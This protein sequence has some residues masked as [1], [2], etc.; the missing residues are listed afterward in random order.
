MTKKLKDIKISLSH[1]MQ[2][3]VVI[4]PLCIVAVGGWHKIEH[5]IKQVET[6]NKNIA[7]C[8]EPE[9]D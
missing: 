8:L 3:F 9:L 6:L 1:V 2:A 4:I 7:A 5:L